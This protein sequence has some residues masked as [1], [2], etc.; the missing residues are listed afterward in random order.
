VVNLESKTIPPTPPPLYTKNRSP[1]PCSCRGRL[2]PT[3]SMS[4][5]ELGSGFASATCRSGN[6][7]I[8]SGVARPCP[9]HLP[10]TQQVE[11]AVEPGF[12]DAQLQARLARRRTTSPSRTRR[13]ACDDRATLVRSRWRT[14]SPRN[15]ASTTP[16]SKL[17]SPA[18]GRPRQAARDA[19]PATPTPASGTGPCPS[20]APLL[21]S[22]S[23]FLLFR[24]S[25]LC[26]LVL[27]WDRMQEF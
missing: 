8:Y 3:T 19:T 4:A 11:V 1:L 26:Y 22:V 20:L 25:M 15:P 9:G 13:D 7:K 14:R 21:L 23:L 5:S 2:P 12:Y 24:K 10:T 18:A 16:S 6:V 17:V 27:M